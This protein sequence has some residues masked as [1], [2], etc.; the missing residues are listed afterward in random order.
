MSGGFV[1]WAVCPLQWAIAALGAVCP[2]QWAIAA[3][4]IERGKKPE[5][6]GRC[7][8]LWWAIAAPGAVC[9]PQWAIAAPFDEKEM[10]KAE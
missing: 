7:V 2:P 1:P 3:P 10:K 6:K 5:K 8:H 4:E 9:P